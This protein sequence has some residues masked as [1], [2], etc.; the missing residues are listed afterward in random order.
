MPQI[1]GGDGYMTEADGTQTFMFAFG[2]HSG[3]AD[4]AAGQPSTQFPN[5][6]NGLWPGCTTESSCAS[7][8]LRGDP[9]TT[10]GAT[11][12]A[13]PWTPADPP[14]TNPVFKW[15]GA[16]GLTPEIATIVTVS[17]IEEG[18]VASPV[19]VPGCPTTTASANTVTAWTDAP[20][21][22]EDSGQHPTYKQELSRSTGPQSEKQTSMIG[23][24]QDALR[25][26]RGCNSFLILRRVC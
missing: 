16:V 22:L 25:E 11:S 6:F 21:R 2:P 5:V 12:G 4:V 1:S 24:C 7:P 9:A 18:P 15:N 13:S 8:L 17:D 14:T 26:E 20:Y 10:D 3:L 19:T 23:L